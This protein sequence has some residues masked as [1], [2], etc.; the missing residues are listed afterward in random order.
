MT[1]KILLLEKHYVINYESH[2][3]YFLLQS[4]SNRNCW[5]FRRR[6]IGARI[7]PVVIGSLWVRISGAE[8]VVTRTLP[9]FLRV[10]YALY[11]NRAPC[12][13]TLFSIRNIRHYTL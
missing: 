10:F 6:P 1:L 4:L 13:Y 3:P 5:L 9:G 7:T 11:Q 12:P 8:W 2:L